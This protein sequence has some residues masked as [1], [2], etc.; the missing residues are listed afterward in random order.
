MGFYDDCDALGLAERVRKGEVRAEELLEEACRR[1]EALNPQLNAV[2]YRREQAA[3]REVEAGLPEGPLQGVPFLIKDLH[4]HIAG[5]PLTYGSRFLRG[6]VSDHDS[7]LTVR[8]RR[9]GLVIFGRTTSPEFGITTT[10]ESALFGQ[11]RNPW[12]PSRSTGGSS[13]GAA[14]VV[15][16]GIIPAA[17]ATD[18]GGSIRIPASCCGVFGLKPTRARNPMGPTQ[19]EGWSG[20][21]CAHAITRSVRDSAALLD[22][23]AGPDVGDPYCAPPLE[24]A[25]QAEAGA[26]PDRLRVALQTRAFNG[27]EVHPECVAAAANAARICEELG[28]HV[29]EAELGIDA[30]RLADATRVIAASNLRFALEERARALGRELTADDVEPVT[31]I[32]AQAAAQATAVDYARSISTLHATGRAAGRFFERWDVLL[33]PTLP[34]PPPPLGALSLTTTDL[35]GFLERLASMTGFTQ[36][37]NASGHPAMSVP[38]HWSPEG[39]PIGVQFAARFGDEATLFRLGAQL[40]SA[41]PWCDRRPPLQ[42]RSAAPRQ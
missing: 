36:L 1:V 24:R 5:E 42:S 39:L 25:F 15:A 10:T 30:G 23:T 26:A 34:Q 11:T 9:A 41:R 13:G 14:A 28:H 2:V 29:E 12:D 3:L 22:A 20:M 33:T 8:Q 4:S 37:F 18:G 21:S 35:G 16:A 7:E 40:E 27:A 32:I 17:H 31:W 38:L 6:F 19:G